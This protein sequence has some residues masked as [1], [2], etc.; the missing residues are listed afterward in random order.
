[1][2]KNRIFN[3]T[4]SCKKM[5]KITI[6]A[7]FV[8]IFLLISNFLYADEDGYQIKFRIHGKKD[9]L[10]MIAYYYSNGTYIKDTVKLDGSGRCTYKP[11]ELPRGLYVFVITDK[12]YFDFVV[13]NDHR[14]SMETDYTD[15][16]NKMVI[17]D[18][19][20]NKLFY[21]YLVQNR[22]KYQEIENLQDLYK[23]LG[24]PKDSAQ[25]FSDRISKINKELIKF[26]LDMVAQF[27]ESFTALMIK[28]MK[29]P[30]I[31]NSDI[32]TLPD[33]RK[34]SAAAYRMYKN[35][36]WEGVDF[37][38][39][40]VLRTPVFHNKL[41]KYF[42]KIVIQQ[43][44]TIIGEIDRMVEKCRPNPEMF[45]YIIWFTT[46]TFEN[47]EIMGFDKIFVHIVDKYYVTGQTTWVTP[48]VQEKIIKKSNKIK[49]LLIGKIAP[50]MIM[51]DTNNQLVSMHHI[52][53]KYTML[54]FWDPDCSH[55]E[56]EIPI[57]VSFYN[58]NKAKYGL[59]VFAIC[60]D[61]SMV[62]MKNAIKKKKM[63]W[64][65]VDGPRTAT[66]DYH[67]QY[68]IISTPVIYLLNER[69]EIIAKKLAANKI[70]VF[71]ENYIKNPRQP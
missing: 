26:K 31:L 39:A 17:K 10:G 1:M 9:T 20:E 44:D 22:T 60:S 19:P 63:P 68:D 46:Y 71:L 2:V 53:A 11:A 36:Y 49:P 55:C 45:K 5:R 41:K 15:P 35:Q 61:T 14:F 43:T 62:K 52:Q 4:L 18:S 48:D 58:E 32:P 69:K 27:P 64:I 23:S 47:S 25:Y 12:I 50:N 42:E 28:A 66:G 3:S 7:I 29:E 38:D 65:N 16:I 37:T 30:E 59:E 6:S 70:D 13:N 67:E 24:E 8:Y 54:L 34:D 21:Q 56:H 51:L 33:G 40:R 57:I